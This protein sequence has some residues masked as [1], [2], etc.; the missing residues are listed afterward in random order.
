M[1]NRRDL[2]FKAQTG[3]I[4]DLKDLGGKAGISR[5][6]VGDLTHRKVGLI[7]KPDHLYGH[8][9]KRRKVLECGDPVL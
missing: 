8:S 4:C 5:K 6:E 2:L 9:G 7:P 1:V 3:G